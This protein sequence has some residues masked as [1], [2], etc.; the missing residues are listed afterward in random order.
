MNKRIKS[1]WLKALRSGKY[2]QGKYNLRDSEN[3]YCCLG[4][5]CDI[6]AKENKKRWIKSKS[7]GNYYMKD[8]GSKMYAMPSDKVVEWAFGSKDLPNLEYENIGFGMAYLNDHRDRTFIE[9]AA[10]I[11]EQL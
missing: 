6:Y 8:G 1:K 2:E 4:V 3:K 9:I 7:N 5:L 11:E 10:L